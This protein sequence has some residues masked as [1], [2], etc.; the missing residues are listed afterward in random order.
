MEGFG[1]SEAQ[2]RR[3]KEVKGRTLVTCE[4]Q[5]AKLRRCYRESWIGV[6]TKEHTE[7]WDCFTKVSQFAVGP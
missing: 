1:I 7:F 5:H 2:R 4:E 3:R 6:C